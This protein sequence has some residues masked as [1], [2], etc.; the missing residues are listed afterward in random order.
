MMRNITM[1]GLALIEAYEGCRLGAYQDTGGVWTIGYGH[2][3]GV[4]EGDI[5]DRATAEQWLRED[6]ASAETAV[7]HLVTVPLTDNQF[8]ALV[9][10][11]F[12]VGFVRFAK[13]TLLRR[14]NEGN[15]GVVPGQMHLWVFDNGRRVAGLARRRAAEAALWSAA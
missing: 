12:N 5:C 3:H 9:S 11:V 4:K 10:F 2:T 8:S 15:Y 14:L 7:S 1:Q 13:S 6:I